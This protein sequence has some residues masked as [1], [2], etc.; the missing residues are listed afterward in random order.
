MPTTS[1]HPIWA[2]EWRHDEANGALIYINKKKIEDQKGV[3][4]FIL[5]KI[6]KNLLSGK[7]ILNISLPVDIFASE[8]NLERLIISMSYAP[9]LLEKCRDKDIL[10]K[11][12]QVVA[13]GIT[14]SVLYLNIE[15]PFNPIL[16]ETLQ[17]WINGCPVYAEQISHHPPI[18]ALMFKGRG[19]EITCTINLI[20]RNSSRRSSC[21]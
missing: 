8:S 20:Q 15:K 6:G 16:G 12:K 5:T 7:S 2:Q 21:T 18:G 13:Y 4:K 14:N 19:Y 17:C 10:S 9:F 1:G 11:F 3:L